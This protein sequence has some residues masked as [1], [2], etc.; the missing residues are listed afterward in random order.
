MRGPTGERRHRAAQHAFALQA[1]LFPWRMEI[2]VAFRDLQ[3]APL[4]HNPI[5]RTTSQ[6]QP[7]VILSGWSKKAVSAVRKISRRALPFSGAKIA[8]NL[9]VPRINLQTYKINVQTVLLKII[10][11]LYLHKHQRTTDETMFR[12]EFFLLDTQNLA[13]DS[14]SIPIPT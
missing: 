3:L 7:L 1:S 4:I 14:Y 2:P 12:A 10:V 8:Q 13:T 9:R 5:L 11:L 6:H